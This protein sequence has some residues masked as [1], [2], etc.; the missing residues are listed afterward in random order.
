MKD[1]NFNGL[2]QIKAD[3][4]LI[5][6]TVNKVLSGAKSHK[7]FQAKMSIAAAAS[8]LV[9][10]SAVAFN[11]FH[12]RGNDGNVI[13][14]KTTVDSQ[15][16][17][18]KTV[19]DNKMSALETAPEKSKTDDSVPYSKS[20]TTP[21]VTTNK[22]VP[23]PSS[24]V[25]HNT[26]VTS[27]D[28][29]HNNTVPTTDKAPSNTATTTDKTH[30]N[31]VVGTDKNQN[32]T[33]PTNS[34]PSSNTSQNK[35]EVA[36]NVGN[37]GIY[38][39]PIIL[40]PNSGIHGK[41]LALVVY[42]GKV[43][44]QSATEI[45]TKNIAN[46]M[47]EKLGCSVNSID[48]WNVKDKSSEEFA[49]NIGEQDIYTVKGY[50]PSFRIMSYLKI[51][52]QEYAQF[53]DCLNGITIKSGNDVFGKLNLVNNVESVKFISFDDWNNGIDNYIDFKDINLLNEALSELKNA[54]PYNLEDI[55]SDIENSRNNDGFRQFDLKLKDGS[56]LK[57]TVYKNGYVLY[58]Y[59]NI[60]F[61]VDSS[62]I[63]KLW[64]H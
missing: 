60:Y 43:Y 44:T 35:G 25:T 29:T 56:E 15:V 4:K 6:N 31:P 50:D 61:K 16:K 42:N 33:T 14:N 58:G 20:G 48:E 9:V 55:E 7:Y 63:D 27:S 19:P 28:K 10:F 51:E 17:L 57:L 54:V 32:N 13:A 59:T 21:S 62:V 34:V 8:V 52:G 41:M 12:A 37:T 30:N 46:F 5:D 3:K 24:S 1:M 22:D 26:T 49:S 11:S 2:D 40:N 23:G 53:F 64:Q 18:N 36:S 38:V 47:G 45:D 39:P